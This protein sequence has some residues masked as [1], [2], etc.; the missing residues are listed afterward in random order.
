M[1]KASEPMPLD[2]GSTTVRVMA[3][4]TAASTALPPSASIRR[5]ACAASGCDVH[6]TFVARMGMRGQA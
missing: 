1:L 3:V 5:P 2:T 4:A 6:T